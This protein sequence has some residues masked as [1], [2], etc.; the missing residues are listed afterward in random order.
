MAYERGPQRW[1]T[2]GL[3]HLCVALG[4]LG[5]F[6]P[7]LPT[8]PFLLLA[9]GLY[10]KASPR[11]EAWLLQHPRLGPP[12]RAW[13]ESGVIGRRA[14]V[15]ALTSMALSFVFV[16]SRAR[17]PLAGKIGAGVVLATCATFVY[18]RPSERDGNSSL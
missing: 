11:F 15:L 10:A 2:L 12:V 14:K 13:K 3:G 7:L 9:A 1:L 6:L 18:T 17:I 8:T 16:C 5:A 4:V